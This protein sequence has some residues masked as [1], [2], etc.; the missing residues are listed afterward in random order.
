MNWDQV[1]GNWI[2]F[3][4]RVKQKWG[5]LTDD[6][7]VVIAGRRD[8]LLGKLLERYGYGKNAAERELNEFMRM[9]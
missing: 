2:L 8:E 4:G 7:L 6:D 1:E 5:K 9:L 3:A